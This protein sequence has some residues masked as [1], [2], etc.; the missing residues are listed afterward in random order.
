MSDLRG[1]VEMLEREG[2]ITWGDSGHRERFLDAERA[3]RPQPESDD[4]AAN[5][6]RQLDRADEALG[7]NDIDGWG[8]DGGRVARIHRLMAGVHVGADAG[9]REAVV[10]WSA[11][12]DELSNA[13]GIEEEIAAEN[14]VNLAEIEL[15]A[16]AV[17]AA[18]AVP[19]AVAP[20]IDRE[21]MKA[22]RGT[23][24]ALTTISNLSDATEQSAFREEAW[25]ALDAIP[26]AILAA[27]AASPDPRPALSDK[28]RM[29][30]AIRDGDEETVT[31][32][33]RAANRPAPDPREETTR[34]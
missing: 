6:Q 1:A 10:E 17:R 34:G 32:M 13:E 24:E 8:E 23:V 25:A 21:R 16:Q 2:V 18:L 33:I 7:C 30:Q 14:R 9:L 26:D 19:H 27:L 15:H 31:G 28:E 3:V 4:L 20:A 22:L 5:L 12:D 29:A 11:A